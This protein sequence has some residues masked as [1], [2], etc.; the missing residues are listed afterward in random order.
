MYT[1]HNPVRWIDPSGLSL[2]DVIIEAAR[3]GV[4][5]REA[6]ERAAAERAAAQREAANAMAA[7]AVLISQ[8]TP[9]TRVAEFIKSWEGFSLTRY[10]ANPPHGDWTIGWGHKLFDDS[11]RTITLQEAEALFAAD[12][13]RMVNTSLMQFLIENDILLTQYQ[14]DAMVSFTFNFGQNIWN[15]SLVGDRGAAMRN[16][17]I[18]GDFS[19]EATR[20]AFS[21][22][23]GSRAL[24][25]HIRRREAELNMFLFGIYRNN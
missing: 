18:A 3:L 13:N 6:N 10:D 14:F 25:G 12:M 16:F 1:L 11:I 5:I 23:M 22:Y 4:A 15:E 21:V 8:L 9:S 17:L 7:R 2:A 24:P 19:E 20:A